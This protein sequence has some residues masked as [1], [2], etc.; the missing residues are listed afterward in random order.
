MAKRIHPV[1]EISAGET[2]VVAID[3]QDQ[4]DGAETLTGSPTF[5][6]VGTLT[7]PNTDD[8]ELTAGTSDLTF[9]NEGINGSSLTINKRTVA[10][11]KAAQAKIAG[12]VEGKDYLVK[13]SIA[14]TSTPAR[15]LVREFVLRCT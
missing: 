5:T 9:G 10:A 11:S 1:V 4:L 14:T 13:F 12:Q 2:E 3:M 15:T 8:E 6:E 7:D